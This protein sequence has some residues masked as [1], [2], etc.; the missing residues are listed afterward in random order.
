MITKQKSTVNGLAAVGGVALGACAV[1]C[2]PIV[3][4]ALLAFGAAG[5]AGLAL[6]GQIGLGLAALG[7]IGLFVLVRRRAARR[8]AAA[9]CGCGPATSCKLADYSART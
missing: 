8:R 3:G 6:F 7:G 2:A 4:S 5:G 1:C 9:A